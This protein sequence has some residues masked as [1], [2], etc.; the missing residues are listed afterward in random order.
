[1]GV[2]LDI[3]ILDRVDELVAPGVTLNPD[4]NSYGAAEL[5]AQARRR[6]AGK[7]GVDQ[8]DL[9]ILHQALPSD[10]GK[11]LEAYRGT[12]AFWGAPSACPGSF[13]RGRRG[14]VFALCRASARLSLRLPRSFLESA[15]SCLAPSSVIGAAGP[16]CVLHIPRPFV[17]RVCRAWG[18]RGSGGK[19]GT[20]RLGA[21]VFQH[22]K[23]IAEDPALPEY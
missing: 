5:T 10:F 9:L 19:P 18:G 4:D 7:L 22:P 11:T 12:F 23:V 16:H 1:V 8:I 20:G 14:A 13:P 2:T 6:S 17:R 15:L 3:E 21:P